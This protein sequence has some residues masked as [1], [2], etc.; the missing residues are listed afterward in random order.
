[1][2][3]E[4]EDY[5]TGSYITEFISGGPKC[6]GYTVFSTNT[7]Q[8]L[9]PVCKMKGIRI[10]YGTSMIANFATLKGMTVDD[11]PPVKLI[12]QNIRR[13]ASHDV[14]TKSEEKIL[15]PTFGKRKRT[16]HFDSVPY[17][18]KQQRC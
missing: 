1:M 9:P 16:E 5:G 3:D 6:Y 7:N 12:S 2:T 4:L 14:I 8:T 13:T 10:S 17:G 11:K 15:K 18:Y